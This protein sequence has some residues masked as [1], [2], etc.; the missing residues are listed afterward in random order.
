MA[1]SPRIDAAMFSDR[2]SNHVDSF[3]KIGVRFIDSVINNTKI[4]LGVHKKKVRFCNIVQ[5]VL[6]H[7][8][9]ELYEANLF[10]SL[11]YSR[12]DYKVFHDDAIS[13]ID[14]Y[15]F[16]NCCIAKR[17]YLVDT[18][19]FFDP[20]HLVAVKQ[21]ESVGCAQLQ[22]ISTSPSSVDDTCDSASLSEGT[23]SADFKRGEINPS[24]YSFPIQ[25]MQNPSQH[26]CESIIAAIIMY[27]P[28]FDPQ[29]EAAFG[30]DTPYFH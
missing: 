15:R 3:C 25:G 9:L 13:E 6:I 10:T 26:E 4:K 28:F 24:R 30:D 14:A 2:S 21:S 8:R 20:R 27:Q 7:S 18:G 17:N 5:V 29:Q 19:V 12:D 11:Y 1:S 23:I 22:P 16:S